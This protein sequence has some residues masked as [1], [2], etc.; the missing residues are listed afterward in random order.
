MSTAFILPPPHLYLGVTDANIT[1]MGLWMETGVKEKRQ[2]TDRYGV[3]WEAKE[4]V[5]KNECRDTTRGIQGGESGAV[6]E[7]IRETVIT[8]SNLSH[9]DQYK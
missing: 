6:Q 9:T 1:L 3:R 5:D 2:V 4:A 8:F 7:L